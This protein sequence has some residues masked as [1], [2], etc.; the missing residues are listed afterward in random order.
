M[1]MQRELGV[2]FRD[3]MILDPN[4]PTAWPSTHHPAPPTTM[5]TQLLFA[6]ICVLN[7]SARVDHEIE[8]AT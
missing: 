1:E 8:A 3:L 6:G 7:H 2:P 5:T 4:L